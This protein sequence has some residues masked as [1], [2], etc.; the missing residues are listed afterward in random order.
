MIGYVAPGCNVLRVVFTVRL[1][2]SVA[3]A[4]LAIVPK[5]PFEGTL[6]TV[7][8]TVP[9]VSWVKSQSSVSPRVP[10]LSVPL[11]SM[12]QEDATFDMCRGP[13]APGANEIVPVLTSVPA[14]CN[15]DPA[16]LALDN[17]IVPAF[18][19]LYLHRVAAGIGQL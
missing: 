3:D 4:L 12:A 7:I 16:A 15:S 18:V 17:V 11:L 9:A 19:P 13:P 2:P 5:R 14:S 6:D 1:P 8:A 10:R